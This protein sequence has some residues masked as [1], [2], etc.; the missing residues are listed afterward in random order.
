MKLAC[1]RLETMA[2]RLSSYVY[3]LAL[4]LVVIWCYRNPLYNFDMIPYAS[5]ALLFGEHDPKI[6]HDQVYSEL[7]TEVPAGTYGA[8]A[9]APYDREIAMDARKFSEALPLYSTKPLYV[10][11]VYLSHRAGFNL[12]QATVVPSVL[13]YAVLG[14]LVFGWLGHFITGFYRAIFSSFIVFSPPVLLLARL[15]A[16]DALSAVLVAAGLYFAIERQSLSVSSGMLLASIYARTNNVIL[17]VIVFGYLALCARDRIRLSYAKCGV[18][19]GV[20]IGSVLTINHFSGFYGWQMLFYTSLL[21]HTSTPAETVVHVSLPAYLGAV[22]QGFFSMALNG[23]Q[24]AF[25]FLGFLAIFLLRDVRNSA[26]LRVYLHLTVGMLATIPLYFLLLPSAGLWFIEERYFAPQYLLLAVACVVGVTQETRFTTLASPLWEQGVTRSSQ[27]SAMI[28][29]QA[30]RH[31]E[32]FG[33]LHR[34]L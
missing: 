26:K 19:V 15:S 28:E 11:A 5:L 18:L 9:N 20:A 22:T 10:M 24:S 12:A 31:A 2:N 1:H 33:S 13:C 8:L 16:P 7:K 3:L 30:G 32:R 4:L 14:V 34:S 29:N 23:F 17:V 25:A 27:Q 6:A 21:G